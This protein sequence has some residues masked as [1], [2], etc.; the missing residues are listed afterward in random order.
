MN[1]KRISI[2]GTVQGVFFRASTKEKADEHGVQGWV[3]NVE[4]GSV[5]IHA[6]GP[7]DAMEQFIA[8]CHEGPPTANVLNVRI[9]NVEEDS[10]SSFEIIQ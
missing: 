5:E 10:F 4:D 7:D 9:E 8:W 1:V 2:S 6:Q 3:R